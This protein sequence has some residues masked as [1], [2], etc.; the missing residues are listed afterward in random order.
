MKQHTLQQIIHRQLRKLFVLVAG[1]FM[2]LAVESCYHIR[3]GTGEGIASSKS[4]TV[5]VASYMWGLI[6]PR[7]TVGGDTPAVMIATDIHRNFGQTLV[8][9]L[10]LGIYIPMTAYCTLV[11]CTHSESP[12]PELD[13]ID[14]RYMNA[15]YPLPLPTALGAVMSEGGPL[16]LEPSTVR[17]VGIAIRGVW[18]NGLPRYA[19]GGEFAPVLMGDNIDLSDYLGDGI[20]DRLSRIMIRTRLSFAVESHTTGGFNSALGLRWMLHDD[21]DLRS[22]SLFAQTVTRWNR[23][24][25]K[26]AFDS[27]RDALKERFWNRSVFEIALAANYRSRQQGDGSIVTS[28]SGYHGFFSAGFPML[29]SS[30]QVQFGVSGWG[31]FA[32][33]DPHYQRQGAVTFRAMYGSASGRLF[34]GARL[35]A[36]SLLEP[37]YRMDLGGLVRIGNGFWLRPDIGVSLMRHPLRGPEASITM[38]FGTPELRE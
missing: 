9:L 11:P 5:V 6:K 18:G 37:D 21:A 4:D 13:P 10:T 25:G 33:D 28:V 24:G 31:G 2:L 3:M 27:L 32:E 20:G 34:A 19:I 7:E 1:I 35:V 26:P 14:I 16:F 29:G 22:D 23:E 36:T 8:S 15:D 12:P 30:G 38:S 17:N